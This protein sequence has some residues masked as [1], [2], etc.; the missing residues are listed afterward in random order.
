MCLS[1]QEGGAY[2]LHLKTAMYRKKSRNDIDVK[3][4][5]EFMCMR[6]WDEQLQEMEMLL[7]QEIEPRPEEMLAMEDPI[8]IKT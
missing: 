8:W 1:R 5:E 3:K 6:D 4:G 7:C 2:N